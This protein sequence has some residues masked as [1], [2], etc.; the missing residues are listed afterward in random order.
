M[1]SL[2]FTDAEFWH[3]RQQTAELYTTFKQIW[4]PYFEA[5]VH[6]NTDGFRHIAFKAWNR[7]RD[8]RDQFMRLK[9]LTRA[10][11]ILEKS[12]TVQGTLVTHEWQRRR[13]HGRREKLLLAVTYYEFIA[14]LNNRRFK[15]IVKERAG[16]ERIFWSLIPFWGRTR[17]GKRVLHEGNPAED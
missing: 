1:A 15:V 8:K 3:L 2:D 5:P 4:C 10:P 9:F 12:H 13:R 17:E 11:V 14:V 7:G 16:G 6:F